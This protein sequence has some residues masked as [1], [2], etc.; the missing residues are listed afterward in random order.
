M[1]KTMTYT[2]E[3]TVTSCWCGIKLAIPNSLYRRARAREVSVYCPL[4][5]TFVFKESEADLLRKDLEQARK[6]TEW[7][8]EALART[9]ADRDAADRSAAAY[10]GHLTRLRKKIASGICPVDGCRRNFTNVKGH[11]ERMHPDWAHEHPD[12]LASA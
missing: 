6:T 12:A 3:L 10:K 9:Q 4:G 5:H 11:I 8:S 1:T 7:Y 2:G